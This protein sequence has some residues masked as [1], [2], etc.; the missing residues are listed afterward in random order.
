MSSTLKEIENTEPQ[1]TSAERGNELLGRIIDA[2]GGMDRWNSYKKV[3][4]TIVSGGGLFSLKGAPQDSAPRRMAA[5]LH[6]ERSSVTPYGA[7]NQRT[8]FTPDRIAIEKLDGAVVA[9][10]RARLKTRS[11]V[12]K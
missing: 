12:T 7:P 2:H 6:E 9:E 11:R 4:A 8:M 10:R 1:A 3:E 5:W